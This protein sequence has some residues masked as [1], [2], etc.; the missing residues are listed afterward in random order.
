[1]ALGIVTFFAAVGYHTADK[2]E[3]HLIQRRLES[4]AQWQLQ[5]LQAGQPVALP[6]GLALYLGP[7]VPQALRA[8]P[9]GFHDV[10][11]APTDQDVVIGTTAD[12]QRY[13]LVDEES[14]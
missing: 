8:L 1:M 10:N 13:A 3:S 12:G 7:Q 4:L 9:A 11:A 14:D 2:V 5:R 6:P